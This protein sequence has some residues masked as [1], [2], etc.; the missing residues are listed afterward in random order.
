MS[1]RFGQFEHEVITIWLTQPDKPDRDMELAA[2]F[3]YLDPAGKRW[4]APSGSKIDGASIPPFLW[5]IVGPPYVGDYRRATVLHDV[6]CDLRTEPHEDVHRMFYYAMRCDG[7]DPFQAAIM[8]LAV[9][10][11]GPKWEVG[12]P[13]S[14]RPTVD[15]NILDY[16]KL[17]VA[18]TGCFN[19]LVGDTALEALDGRITE[20]ITG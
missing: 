1:D 11:F 3:N 13:E 9:K 20:I 17:K 7:V 10:H 8:Y 12:K 6:G 16:Y 4:E 15:M 14:Y 18:L 2:G 19:L 5:T